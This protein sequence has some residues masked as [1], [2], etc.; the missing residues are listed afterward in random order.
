MEMNVSGFIET[1][2]MKYNISKNTTT[3]HEEC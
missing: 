2:F 3:S 1:L